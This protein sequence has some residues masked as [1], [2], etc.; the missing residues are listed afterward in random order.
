[1][2]LRDKAL[3]LDIRGYGLCLALNQ[4]NKDCFNAIILKEKQERFIFSRDIVCKY[5]ISPKQGFD[6]NPKFK[7]KNIL[8]P[9]DSNYHT[10]KRVL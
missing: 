1:M 8:I 2:I 6:I 5:L 7:I 10:I 4:M 9:K 3:Y